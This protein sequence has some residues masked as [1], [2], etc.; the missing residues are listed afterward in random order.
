M[1]QLYLSASCP[2]CKKVVLAASQFGLQE[3]KDFATIDAAPGTAG[4]EVV[5]SVGGKTMVPFL[6]DG[7]TSMYESDDIV[8][9]LKKKVPQN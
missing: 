4:R 5:L 6:I 7:D 9:Y 1:I 8:A 3:G 2:F